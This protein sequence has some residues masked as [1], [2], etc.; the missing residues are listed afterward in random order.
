MRFMDLTYEPGT[1]RTIHSESQSRTRKVR[2]AAVG[3]PGGA[4]WHPLDSADRR[5]LGRSARAIFFPKHANASGAGPFR[6]GPVDLCRF[7]CLAYTHRPPV[8]V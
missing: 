2:P 8:G 1:Y 4:Q 5:S 7:S 3:L 6:S